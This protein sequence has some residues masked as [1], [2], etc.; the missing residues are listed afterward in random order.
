MN[1]KYLIR[2]DLSA[3]VSQY[4]SNFYHKK[5]A[6]TLAEGATHVAHWKDSRKVAFT[7]AEVLITLGIIGIV[8]A[9]T[10]PNL[11]ANY[12]KKVLVTRIKRTYS[13]IQNATILA[14]KDN[15]SIGDNSVLFN[16][17]D[18]YNK[19]S[20]NFAKFFSGAKICKS[21]SECPNFY[22]DIEYATPL[23]KADGTN[24]KYS[25]SFPLIVLNDGSIMW[26][27]GLNPGCETH[28]MD[29]Y[30]DK[31]GQ[32]HLAA[33]NQYHCA[34]IYFDVNG[35]IVPNKFGEDVFLLK[36][37][38]EKISPNLWSPTG[39]NTLSNILSGNER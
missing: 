1:A 36:V 15:D 18:G 23:Y 12:Q 31:N 29:T 16:A 6:F 3:L 13:N 33:V 8:A 37:Y 5:S 26:V 14:Q 27:V 10:L 34:G 25:S 4:P 22:Y 17:A 7:L 21:R 2:K 39:G 24:S 35:P 38:K 32:P 20:E 28:R 9:L 19:V 30:Y 11:I